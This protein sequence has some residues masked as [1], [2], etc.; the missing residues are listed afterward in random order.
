MVS[1]ILYFVM[2]L[3]CKGRKEKGRFGSDRTGNGSA[4]TVW[5]RARQWT[6][7]EQVQ[8]TGYKVQGTR[9]KARKTKKWAKC[10][11]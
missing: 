4:G 6:S 7:Y 8:I 2:L 9:L 10:Y 1:E 5:Q 11:L 3:M